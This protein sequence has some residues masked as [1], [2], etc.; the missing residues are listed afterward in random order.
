MRSLFYSF[1]FLT[2]SFCTA[3]Q[4]YSTSNKKAIKAYEE[5]L[6]S[7]NRMD[8]SNASEIMQKAIKYDD[9]FIEAHIVLAEIFVEKGERKNA[10]TSY[11]NVIRINP[12]F[13][14]GMYFSLA[15][16]EMME[17]EFESAKSHLENYLTYKNL[18]PISI[19]QAKQK[20]ESCNFAI[21][22][23]KNPVPFSPVN[24]GENVNTEYDEYW[25]SLTADEQTLIITRLIPKEKSTNE[26][27]E[28]EYLDEKD[29][30][31]SNQLALPGLSNVQED[32]FISIKENDFWAKAI[33][34]GEPLNTQGNE[35]A[36][37]ILTDGS[38][39]YF[40]A[41]NRADGKGRCDIYLSLKENG[42]WTN[43]INLGS[44]INS[45]YWEAQPSISPDGKTL[46]FV[47]NR[48]GGF[49][50]KDIWMS[51][52]LTDGRWSK[53]IN[54]GKNIN[55]SGDEQ[56]PFIHPDNKTLYFASDGK[57]G[58]GGFDLFKVSRNDDGSWSEPFN[59]GYPI[60]T[61]SDEIGFIVN[62][63]GDRAYFSSDRLSEMGRDIFEFE[64][65]KE[66][67]PNP[68]SYIKGKVYDSENQKK[69]K[70]HFELISLESNKIVM[71]AESDQITGEFLVCI[72]TDNDYALNVSKEGY[73][74]YSDNFELKGVHEIT[75]PYLKDVALNPIKTGQKI[76]LRNVFYETDSYELV[77]KSV[78]ELTKL[79]D[80]LNHN[81]GLKIEISGHTDNVGTVD[82]NLG[83]SKN[84]AKSVYHYLT[85]NGINPERLSYKGY[86]ESQAI[87]SNETIEGR[88]DNRRTEIKILSS[89]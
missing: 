55:S 41:C 79:I 50:K 33:N 77:D 12:D 71:Q 13:F 16:L 29:L 83:L 36:Q 76:I 21:E 42:Q 9:K 37:T 27:S 20:L 7:F 57:T 3:A 4:N 73:L 88:A 78:A 31:P 66:A 63:K 6:Q 49:G 15:Q 28:T 17:N 25:P 68:V 11:Q 56:S 23:V 70:A 85:E 5:A 39:M 32:F 30:T 52:I 22:A 69:L 89:N 64:L 40:T 1:I 24:L 10:I 54:P 87:S 65:Y 81:P 43:A 44:P 47:S 14:P 72:P 53:P 58:M 45:G 48:E 75:S 74:F 80:F 38:I 84:R 18:K 35:G 60:N 51:N 46:Y 61:S 26:Y 82:Y 19:A 34:A 62:A 59:L 67:R 8:Y 2:I 86:G